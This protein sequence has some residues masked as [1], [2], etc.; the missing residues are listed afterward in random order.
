[1][2]E[3]YDPYTEQCRTL[4]NP[5]MNQNRS[6]ATETLFCGADHLCRQAGVTGDHLAD[7]RNS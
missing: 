7:R 4:L 2:N 5:D 6:G 3:A 1:M